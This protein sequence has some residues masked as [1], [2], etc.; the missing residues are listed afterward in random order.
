MEERAE[1]GLSSPDQGDSYGEHEFIGDAQPPRTG[2]H[3]PDESTDASPGGS[4]RRSW[5]VVGEIRQVASE[6]AL[7]EVPES[8]AACLAEAQ[9]LI[10]ARDRLVSAV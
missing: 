2:R 1:G 9:E 3:F 4:G 7:G 5:V 10:Y 6:L 8:P